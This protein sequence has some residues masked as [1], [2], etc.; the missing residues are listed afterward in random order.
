MAPM[1]K[2]AKPRDLVDMSEEQ[3]RS[4]LLEIIE[5]HN[6]E[7]GEIAE[8]ARVSRATVSRWQRGLRPVSLAHLE[9]V[10]IKIA[11]DIAFRPVRRSA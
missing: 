6:L 11:M 10:I 5:E 2:N 8:L 1:S 4:R 7:P 9:L 3:R